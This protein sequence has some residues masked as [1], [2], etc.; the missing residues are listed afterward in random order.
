MP[1]PKNPPPGLLP[2]NNT[3]AADALI[4]PPGRRPRS[5]VNRRPDPN[6]SRFGRAAAF[7]LVSSLIVIGRGRADQGGE[8]DAAAHPP[9]SPAAGERV[10]NIHCA[11]CHQTGA[12]GQVGYAPSI[13]NRDFL[14]LA[15][16]DFIRR[17]IQGGRPGTAMSPRPDL[18]DEE[19]DGIIAYLR[20]LP[21]ATGRPRVTVDWETRFEGDASAGGVK[22][23]AYCASCHGITGDG[24]GSGGAG[25][26]IGLPGFLSMA[27]DDYILQT[28]KLGRIGTP[29]RSFSGASGL[30]NLGDDDIRDII[31]HMRQLGESYPDRVHLVTRAGNARIGEA[32]FNV[33][34]APCHQAGGTGKAGF[35]PSIRNREFLA[36]A[37]DDFIRNTIRDGREGTGMMARPDLPAQAVEDILAYLRA[38]PIPN[39]IDVEVN[40]HLTFAGD[41]ESGNVKFDLY[42]AAC[43]GP[44]GAGY[45]A[46]GSGPGIGLSGFLKV[47]S[48]DYIFKTVKYGRTG[49]AMKSF[50]GS[51]GLANLSP[52]DVHDI[53]AYLRTLGTSQTATDDASDYE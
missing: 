21:A 19:I 44:Y 6:S 39:P 14:A 45:N 20:S 32:Y 41:A 33:N 47:A 2:R 30:A 38:L 24:Y 28:V 34:C 8:G 5:P 9:V 31:A 29:M 22:Y 51:G 35:A 16:D 25:T 46:G 50:L 12:V 53:I 23:A 36:L 26:A 10:F 7:L 40:P 11:Q 42:C 1:I 37:D 13:R 48:D 4:A 3:I 27:S 52:P 17:T 49:T 18:L 43:H 15:S